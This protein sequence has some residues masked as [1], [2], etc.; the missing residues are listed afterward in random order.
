MSN[1]TDIITVEDDITIIYFD[2][3]IQSTMCFVYHI[4]SPFEIDTI[5]IENYIKVFLQSVHHFEE[6]SNIFE[7]N[8]PFIWYSRGNFLSLLNLPDQI[9]QFGS[10]RL[11]WE[12][13][14]ER[15]IQYVKP[16]MTNIQNTP[17]YLAK[18]FIRFNKEK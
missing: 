8:A 12:G 9:K 4:M 11:Y 5:T 7:Y 14:C 2:L 1:I 13:S 16:L 3:M 18:R 17:T 15:N 6:Y 10:I